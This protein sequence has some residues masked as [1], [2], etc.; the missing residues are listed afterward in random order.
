MDRLWRS[1]SSISSRTGCP[2]DIVNDEDHNVESCGT[3]VLMCLHGTKSKNFKNSIL[4]MAD[5]SLND[6]VYFNY[7][8][9]ASSPYSKTAS[10]EEDDGKSKSIDSNVDYVKQLR[11]LT[12]LNENFEVVLVPLY[13]EFMLSKNRIKRKYFQDNF[14]QSEKNCVK[15]KWLEK[16]NQLKKHILFFDFL[17]KPLY[18]SSIYI[19]IYIYNFFLSTVRRKSFSNTVF[20]F[21]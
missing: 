17:E 13:D 9:E 20:C 3:T 16:M 14:A 8:S 6:Q 2:S 11:V 1:N 15:S 5:V 4:S 10:K 19:Y 18:T 12:V 21:C 7:Y